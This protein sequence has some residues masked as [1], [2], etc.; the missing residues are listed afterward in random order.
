M[1][2][3]DQCEG[4]MPAVQYDELWEQCFDRISEFSNLLAVTACFDRHTGTGGDDIY[5]STRY[6][7]RE[8]GRLLRVLNGS[9]RHPL[10]SLA[11]RHCGPEFWDDEADALWDEVLSNL[12]SLRLSVVHEEYQPEIGVNI[13]VCTLSSL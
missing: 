13:R 5:Q 6:R 10:K 3:D 12:R 8:M 9:T 2:A 1:I 7:V 11:I 4:C